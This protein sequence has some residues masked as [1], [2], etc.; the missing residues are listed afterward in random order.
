MER[1]TDEDGGQMCVRGTGER[2][3]RKVWR[4]VCSP[5]VEEGC[6]N[7]LDAGV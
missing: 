7:K 1:G 6:E 3:D 5:G 2:G 4:Q